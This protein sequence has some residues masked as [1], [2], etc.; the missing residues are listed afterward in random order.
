MSKG[1]LKDKYLD[2]L[3]NDPYYNS[4]VESRKLV[5]KKEEKIN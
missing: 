2:L 5:G 3:N 1:E 4:N